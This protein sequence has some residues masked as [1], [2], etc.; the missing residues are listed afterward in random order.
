M[1]NYHLMTVDIIDNN[2]Y[3]ALSELFML[4]MS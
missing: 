2:G 3:Y 1:R 4:P